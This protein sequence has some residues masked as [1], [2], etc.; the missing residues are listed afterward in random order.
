[1][2]T[3]QKQKRAGMV[4]V[5]GRANVGKSSLL[6]AI[7]GEKLSIVSPVAQTTRNA[8][9]GIHSEDRGQIVFVDTPGIHRSESSLGQVMNKM[10]RA[11]VEGCDAALLVLDVTRT[12]QDE[13]R[14][15]IARLLRE[16]IPVFIALN[17][18][19]ALIGDAPADWPGV[20]NAI[21]AEKKLS[22]EEEAAAHAAEAEPPADGVVRKAPRKN[23]RAPEPVDFDK[24]PQWFKVSAMTGAG[25]P[26]LVSALFDK[27]PEGEPLFPEDML[28]DYPRK[29][30]IADYIREKLFGVLRE[31]LPHAIAVWVE[32]VNEAEDGSWSVNAKIYVKKDSQ[33]GIVLGE[34]GRLLRKIKRQSEAEL[35]S[36]Y[37][38][39][40]TVDL[41]VKV[42][43]DWN[44]N[45]WLLKKFGYVE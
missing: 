41:W 37:E 10:A 24:Q 21:A 44:E 7:L 29:L 23:R 31:E 18:T 12:A 3:Q 40:V 36:I 17:K 2:E 22:Y 43:K 8:I 33:K 38:R 14:G 16:P 30:A 26:E 6:N 13:D 32:S 45:F 19:D 1:M 20:W 27:M 42:E 35:T 9:R 34:K 4:A 39:P 15:W 5:I 28:S 25:V 11:S